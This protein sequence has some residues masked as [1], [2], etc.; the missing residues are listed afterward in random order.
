ML[1]IFINKNRKFK[2]KFHFFLRKIQIGN[3][4]YLKMKFNYYFFLIST[5][6]YIN[7]FIEF[8]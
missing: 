3:M 6:I 2:N 7:I 4:I 8:S 5:G 1:L